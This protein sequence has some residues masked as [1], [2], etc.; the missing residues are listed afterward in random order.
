MQILFL[1]IFLLQPAFANEDL[2]KNFKNEVFRT[3]G[4]SPV[5]GFDFLNESTLIFTERSGHFQHIGFKNKE[6]RLFKSGSK[7]C[8][9]WAGWTFRCKG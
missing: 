8:D 5:W 7:S 9:G 4:N 3:E 6:G 1:I 2:N